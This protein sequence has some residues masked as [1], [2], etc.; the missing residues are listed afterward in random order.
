MFY[1][2][3]YSQ[4]AEIAHHDIWKCSHGFTS[5]FNMIELER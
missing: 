2:Y 3:E 5:N 4:Y 1:G